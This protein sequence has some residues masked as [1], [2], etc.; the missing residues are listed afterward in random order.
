MY[1]SSFLGGNRW[2]KKR[3]KIVEINKDNKKEEVLVMQVIM[4]PMK[5]YEEKSDEQEDNKRK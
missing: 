1:I 4:R 5:K 3:A 2:A